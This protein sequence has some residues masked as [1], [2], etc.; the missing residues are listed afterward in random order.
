M[1]MYRQHRP[2]L[3]S[4]LS[5]PAIGSLVLHSLHVE[6]YI[7]AV[8]VNDT[9]GLNFTD[10]STIAI[11]WQD[12][13][14]VYSGAVSYQLRADVLTGGTT[15]GAL[16]HFTEASMGQN[17]TTTTPWIAYISCDANETGA[18]MEWGEPISATPP[19]LAYEVDIFTLARDRGA[20]SAVSSRRSIEARASLTAQL[21]YTATAASCLLN[22]E[23]IT[24][25]E[26]P[27]DVFATKT[28]QVAR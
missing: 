10:S 20:V 14:G 4:L 3:C 27:L 15:S 7:P 21:L 2:S 22:S 24:D 8:A 16:V 11:A 25:F 13:S 23:Y 18:S 12:I 5:L 26:K 1:E 28:L 6:A 17:L 9:S 19:V